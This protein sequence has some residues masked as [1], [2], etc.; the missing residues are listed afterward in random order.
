MRRLLLISLLIATLAFNTPEIFDPLPLKDSKP[1]IQLF[2]VTYIDTVN[3]LYAQLLNTNTV[4]VNKTPND[5]SL[6]R[7]QSLT[8]EQ[9]DS[10]LETYQ[11]PAKNTGKYFIAEGERTGIDSAYV[12]AMF[13]KESSAGTDPNWVGIKPDKTTTHNIGN[14]RCYTYT[15]CYKGFRDYDSW[16][17]GIR[18]TFDNLAAYK[19]LYGVVTIDDAIKIWSPSIENDTNG[20]VAFIHENVGAWRS[21]ATPT[22]QSSPLDI[23][24]NMGYN[25]RIA[26]NANNGALRN[27]V[28]RPNETWSFNQTVGDPSVLPKMYHIAG[29]YGGGWCDLAGRYVQVLRQLGLTPVF[30][31]HGGIALNGLS[32]QDSPYIWNTNGSV[33]NINGAQDVV[34]TNTTDRT[35]YLTAVE[36]QN[37]LRIV[38][39]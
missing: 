7:S 28:I 19:D 1:K 27:I 18:A 22:F 36:E 31:Q 39:R 12:V 15:P 4:T 25:V 30:E 10:I 20:Y 38:S 29:V 5:W 35:I 37:V 6:F 11:S 24:G 8:A 13:I 3:T 23:S 14:L 16:E 26:L 34:V 33:G 9:I 32:V 17:A 21:V 2:A